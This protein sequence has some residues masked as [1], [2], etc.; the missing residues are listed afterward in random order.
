[1]W[2]GKSKILTPSDIWVLVECLAFKAGEEVVPPPYYL[3][4]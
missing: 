4:I 3:R 2:G 1:M